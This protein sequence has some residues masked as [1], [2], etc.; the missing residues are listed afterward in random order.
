[1]GT[2]LIATVFLTVDSPYILA[3]TNTPSDSLSKVRGLISSGRLL[4]AARACRDY[5]SNSTG[6]EMKKIC[7]DTIASLPAGTRSI[8]LDELQERVLDGDREAFYGRVLALVLGKDYEEAVIEYEAE[9]KGRGASPPHFLTWMAWAYFKTGHTLESTELYRNVLEDNPG[10][11]SASI[12]LAYCYAAEGMYKKAHG[13]L[14]GILKIEPSNKEA[15][16]A[17]AYAHEKAGR[18]DLA[19]REYEN[20]IETDPHNRLARKL[21]LFALS[22]LGASSF[23]LE[24]AERYFPED[25]ALGNTFR[26]VVAAKM[27]KWKEPQRAADL[28][29]Q[30][31]RDDA[32]RKARFDL[33]VA[34]VK[35]SDMEQ[36]V[37]E[38]DALVEEG[39]SVP[40]WVHESLVEAYL[41]LERSREALLHADIAES[42]GPV[43]YKSHLNRANALQGKGRWRKA[44]KELEGLEE[45][46]PSALRFGGSAQPNWPK[47]EAAVAKGWLIAYQGR[48]GKAEDYFFDLYEKAPG[49]TGIRIGLAHVHLWRG[50]PRKALDEFRIIESMGS[51]EIDFLTGKA[52]ALIELGYWA[53]GVEIASSLQRTHPKDVHV[54]ELLRALELEKMRRVGFTFLTSN[55]DDGASNIRARA[56]LFQPLT[57]N[58]GISAGILWDKS[59]DDTEEAFFRRAEL[60]VEHRVAGIARLSETLSIN[61]NDGEDFGSYTSIEIFPTDWS[62]LGAAYDTFTT[63]LPLRARVFD[64]ESDRLEVSARFRKDE[65]LSLGIGGAHQDFSDDNERNELNLFLDYGVFTGNGWSL[66]AIVDLYSSRNSSDDVPYFNPSYDLSSTLTLR[67]EQEVWRSFNRV[68]LHRLFLTAGSYKQADFDHE[69]TGSAR[70]EQYIKPSDTHEIVWGGSFARNVF[71][72]EDVDGYTLYLSYNGRF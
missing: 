71:D 23:A 65:T 44:R 34:L 59:S 62:T 36:A 51:K 8:Y 22:D 16:F 56:Y 48:Y 18:F 49:N 63:D 7:D 54:K 52:S 26:N 25:K 64:I 41:Y 2:L 10:D 17:R 57:F 39:V 60:G 69:F 30:I 68:I 61:Y 6:K 40:Q 31:N 21:R 11:I 1:M 55:E 58:T 67:V 15:I 70:Y 50:W 14:D 5:W 37:R 27:I 32:G 72:G 42:M 20:V 47:L 53:E 28:L 9:L 43:N 4:E 13:I 19:V 38:Y 45:E 29:A 24:Q 66:G 12:G 3:S 46:L 35:N 33:I